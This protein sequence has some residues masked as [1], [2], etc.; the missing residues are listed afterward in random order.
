MFGKKKAR[1]H[2]LVALVVI[3]M[4]PITGT[5]AASAVYSI[6]VT[7]RYR[8]QKG[9]KIKLYLKGHKNNKGVSW[10]SSN[11]KIATVSKKGVVKGKKGGTTTITAKYKKKKYKCK[12]TVIVGERTVYKKNTSPEKNKDRYDVFDTADI[13]KDKL[14][15]YEGK[16]FK[17][18]ITGTKKKITWKSSNKA[19]ATVSPSG[20]VTA[21]KHGNAIIKATY[22]DSK[23][24]YTLACKVTVTPLWMSA[25]DIEKNY[26][27]SFFSYPDGGIHI[28]GASEGVVVPSAQITDIPKSPEVGVEYGTN[29]K[30]KYDGAKILF[31]LKDLDNLGL[32]VK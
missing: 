24:T 8:I 12:I 20:A 29:I 2:C 31:N 32:L 9:E 18:K 25:G 1:F 3:T 21:I 30:Y 17:L 6:K 11:K 10:K 16:T 5:N 14:T 26:G 15:L 19:V 22:E 7:K 28:T 23:Y 4:L 27:A 13:N